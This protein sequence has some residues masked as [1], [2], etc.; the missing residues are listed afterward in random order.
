MTAR[1]R[2]RLTT[3]CDDRCVFCGQHGIA[4]RDE[5][6]WRDELQRAR[7]SSDE[8]SFVGGEPTLVD[9]LPEAIAA[10]RA[11]GFVAIGVQTHAR[12][13]AP[14]RIDALVEAGLG[15]VHV[16]LH[17]GRAAVHDWHEGIDGGFVATTAAIERLRARGVTVVASTVLTRSSFRVIGELPPL[18]A[19]L[20]IAAW[21]V[22]VPHVAGRAA[23]DFDRVVPRLALSLPFALHAM[24]R[25]Q[26][27]GVAVAIAGAP[28]C[29]LGPWA[30]EHGDAVARTYPPQCEGC[31]ARARCAGVDAIYVARFG[32]AELRPRAAVDRA[33]AMP[34]ALAR[35]FVGAGEL[36]PVAVAEHDTPRAARHR[37]PQVGKVARAHDEVRGASTENLRELFPDLFEPDE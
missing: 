19:A 17:G 18:L 16:G 29:L 27:Q 13:L 23:A 28:A 36:V 22:V 31:G 30:A 11:L 15:D 21:T 25:A 20:G 2:V 34:A 9:A 8:V 4:E 5:P 35:M 6:G 7:A 12:H 33:R 1:A 10:A 24:D 32:D 3:R 37:L 26:R 14:A